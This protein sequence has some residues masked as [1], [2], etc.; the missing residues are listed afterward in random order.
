MD[1]DF[2]D[3]QQLDLE[4]TD[5]QFSGGE[6]PGIHGQNRKKESPFWKGQLPS[7]TL[8]QCLCSSLHLSLLALSLNVL[9][10]V[11]VC[12]IGSQSIQLREELQ[13]LK[14]TFSNFSSGTLREVL[15]LGS[16]GGSTSDKLTSLEAQLEEH[17]QDIK[18]DHATLLLHLKHFPTDL[19]ALTCHMVY[20]QSN[21]TKC[22]PVNWV[23][24]GGSCYWFSR[25]GM[26]WREAEAYC[27][28]EN[29]HLVVINSW[30]EQKFIM[31]HTSPFHIWIG[32]SDMEGPWRWVD[33][34]NYE[35]SYQ[36]WAIAQPDNWQGHEVGASEDC[37][38][39]L[40]NGLWNDNF[41]AEV[42]RWA[43]EMKHN[44]T[45]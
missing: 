17:H 8:P 26:N 45:V 32:L 10:L 20:L 3:L 40:S 2:Q 13:A 21:G 1:K 39:V 28:L 9:L 23:R 24:H 14:E 18:A 11:A 43:C 30:D 6:E 31:Q 27:R 16:H 37:V 7:Q 41:C 42:N 33:G 4:E 36:N 12:V 38:E 19:G 44:I 25:A 22:C 29:A 15:A 34:T 35:H 5:H